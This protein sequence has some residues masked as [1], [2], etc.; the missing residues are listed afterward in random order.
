MK[1]VT[2]APANI[3]VRISTPKSK[4]FFA[5]SRNAVSAAHQVAIGCGQII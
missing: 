5:T 4:Y 1:T 2:A 3:F